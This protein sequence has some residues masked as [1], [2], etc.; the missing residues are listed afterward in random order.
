MMCNDVLVD[1]NGWTTFVELIRYPV[2]HEVIFF[3]KDPTRLLSI[4]RERKKQ[5]DRKAFTPGHH[6][7]YL[8]II[9]SDTS[10]DSE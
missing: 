6:I 5:K 1:L 10:R 8:I 3:Y 4:S 7:H 2:L 9:M